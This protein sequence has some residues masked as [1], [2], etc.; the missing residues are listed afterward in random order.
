LDNTFNSPGYLDFFNRRF[1]AKGLSINTT[2]T[3]DLAAN[4][5]RMSDVFPRNSIVLRLSM[6]KQDSCVLSWY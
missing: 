5:E 4:N 2:E 3:S 1:E 6:F